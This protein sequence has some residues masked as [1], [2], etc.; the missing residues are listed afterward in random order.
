MPVIRIP[1]RSGGLKAPA[2]SLIG[3]SP[4]NRYIGLTRELPAVNSI[5]S[6]PPSSSSHF[7]VC[8]ASSVEMPPRTPSAMFSFAV[9]AIGVPAFSTARRTANTVPRATLARLANEPPNSSVRRLISG[10]RN[11]LA[12]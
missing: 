3:T 5:A 11:E 10:D 4:R 8:N 9:T 1:Q 2:N 7:A 6:S 12:K